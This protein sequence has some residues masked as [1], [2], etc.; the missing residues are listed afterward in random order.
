MARPLPADPGSAQIGNPAGTEAWEQ[1][2]SSP[3]G[4]A[5]LGF[6][7]RVTSASQASLGTAGINQEKP[8][9]GHGDNHEVPMVDTRHLNVPLKTRGFWHL[10]EPLFHWEWWEERPLQQKMLTSVMHG[11]WHDPGVQEPGG[12]SQ[13]DAKCH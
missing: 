10:N 7:L 2:Q 13:K 8:R 11:H 12:C 9:E 6:R 5:A 3:Q 4:L 1:R